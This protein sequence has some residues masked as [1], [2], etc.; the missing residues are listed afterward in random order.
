MRVDF[1]QIPYFDL[2]LTHSKCSW[3]INVYTNNT[4]HLEVIKEFSLG[5]DK[6][7][8]GYRPHY[9]QAL[10]IMVMNFT[11]LGLFMTLRAAS[12]LQE[13]GDLFNRFN[14]EHLE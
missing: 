14:W 6:R 10:F 4:V 8:L 9:A 1:C 3:F 2:I 11:L 13:N 7:F 12:N 5:S